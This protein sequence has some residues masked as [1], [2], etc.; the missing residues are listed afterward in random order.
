[1]GTAG[2]VPA[3]WLVERLGVRLL[4]QSP[5]GGGSIHS[6]WCLQLEGAGSRRLFAKTNGASAL[7]QLEAEA[8]GLAALAVAAAATG[9]SVPAPLALGLAGDRAVL[10]LP[11]LERSRPDE[12]HWGRLGAGLARLHRASLGRSCACEDRSDAFG[13]QRDNWIGSGPQIN[14][15]ESDWGRF[16]CERRLAPQAALLARRGLALPGLERLLAWVP[17]WLATHRPEPCLVHGDLWSG[18]AMARLG[19]VTQAGAD[20]SAAAPAEGGAAGP[21]ED[22]AAIF[23]PAVYRGDRE[24]DLAM[25]RLFGGFPAAFFAGYAAVWP[26]AADHRRRIGL[27]NLY[28]LL[29]HANLF[30]GGYLDQARQQIVSCHAAMEQ[31]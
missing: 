5:V 2:G 18:N 30:G 12:E 11:W 25:A 17:D 7:P 19:G 15:W 16:F 21:A 22:G 24:V 9:L 4:S 26:L 27:Y 10:V 31:D 20:P 29:N 23:D 13:W 14:G 6:A 1:M 28:H 3:D 8:D